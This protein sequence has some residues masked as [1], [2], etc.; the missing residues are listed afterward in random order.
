MMINI[1]KIR[2]YVLQMLDYVDG[3]KIYFIPIFQLRFCSCYCSFKLW[4][5]S[6]ICLLIEYV[7][8]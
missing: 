2:K 4:I 6:N 8:I 7:C 3:I 1:A 5:L